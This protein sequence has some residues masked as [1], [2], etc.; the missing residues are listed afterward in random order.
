M[1]CTEAYQR[2]DAPPRRGAGPEMSM[3]ACPSPRVAMLLRPATTTVQYCTG[4]QPPPRPGVQASTS[5][6]PIRD[7][8]VAARRRSACGGAAAEAGGSRQC[9]QGQPLALTFPKEELHQHSRGWHFCG[10]CK[11][12]Q[13]HC[14]TRCPRDRIRLGVTSIKMAKAA[15]MANEISGSLDGHLASQVALRRSWTKR[16]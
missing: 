11:N 3:Q 1:A 12:A 8:Q 9:V 4:A 13:R 10:A 5:R 6:R 2:C 16:R 14:D 15:K 7:R